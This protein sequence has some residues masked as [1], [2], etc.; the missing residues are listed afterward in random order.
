MALRLAIKVMSLVFVGSGPSFGQV[1]ETPNF[2]VTAEHALEDLALARRALETIHP[3]YDR[4][5]PMDTLNAQWEALD[6]AV[7]SQRETG[8][9][10]PISDFYTELSKTLAM[11]RCDHTKAEL[12]DAVSSHLDG[13][14]THLPFRFVWLEDRMI[15]THAAV[16]TGLKPGEEILTVNDLPVANWV[17]RIDPLLPVD[18]DTD[19]TK[20]E[21][22]ARTG[23]FR[24]SALDHFMG[25]DALR[26]GW[27]ETVALTVA[28]PDGAERTLSVDRVTYAD[29]VEIDG[30]ARYRNFK[31]EVEFRTIGDDGAYLAVNTFVN[32]REPVDPDA[33][34]APIFEQIQTEGRDK[35]IVDL[36]ANGGGSDDAMY[37][38]LSYL[39]SEPVILAEEVWVKTYELGDLKDHIKTWDLSALEP[40]PD[41]FEPRADGT[42]RIKPE[43]V[44]RAMQPTEPAKRAFIGELVVL[45]GANNAS[46]VTHLIGALKDGRSDAT[47]IGQRTGGAA[48][49][50]TANVIFFFQLPHSGVSVRIPAQRT[51]T[52]DA[53]QKPQRLGYA[54]DVEV[55]KSVADFRAGRDAT[56]DTAMSHLAMAEDGDG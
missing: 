15:V 12:P 43:I 45:V 32:Y 13:K 17:A 35:L 38:L 36:R 47:L 4:Y 44:G 50:A 22:L 34:Y 18:G 9:D 20:P 54:P 31:D 3:G 40:D 23:E 25:L 37:G 28:S 33:I 14:P 6:Q 51:V 42:Y 10:V 55:R 41:W 11:I 1:P 48:T 7:Q 52:M 49:G 8:K 53:D 29:F 30:G 27:S 19:F 46:G 21:Q 39:I 26:S 5:T 24:G 2:A 56:L 16:Q